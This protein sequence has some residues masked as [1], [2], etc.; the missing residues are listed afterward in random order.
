MD[1]SIPCSVEIVDH[2]VDHASCSSDEHGGTQELDYDAGKDHQ[3]FNLTQK[4]PRACSGGFSGQMPRQARLVSPTFGCFLFGHSLV[5]FS[6]SDSVPQRRS[7][8]H[9]VL[10]GSAERR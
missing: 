9:S 6:G 7:A 1:I 4:S 8:P 2:Q 3:P 5:D 10:A